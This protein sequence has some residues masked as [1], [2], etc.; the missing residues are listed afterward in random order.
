MLATF[1]CT[2]ATKTTTDTTSKAKSTFYP[3]W[4][5]NT[6]FVTDSTF[7]EAS[8]LASHTDS[9][10]AMQRAET[11]SKA[12]LE[13]F[14]S[15]QI[16]RIRIEIEKTDSEAKSSAV[17]MSLRNATAGMEQFAEITSTEVKKNEMGFVGFS[18]AR[19]SK[20]KAKEML[21]NGLSSHNSFWN[22]LSANPQ[23]STFFN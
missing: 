12:E 1:A 8:A 9:L 17:L 15:I 4:Y 14:I 6:E 22:N 11:Q 21:R 19:I 3:D 18:N 23:F 10:I 13:N 5:H 16:E 2:T 7:F 20:T